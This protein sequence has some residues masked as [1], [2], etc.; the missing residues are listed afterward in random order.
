MSHSGSSSTTRS[1]RAPRRRSCVSRVS[2]QGLVPHDR[3]AR[4]R[5]R[6][7]GA[8]RLL[9]AGPLPVSYW[10]GAVGGG[11]R[12]RL[13]KLQN[14][15]A[16]AA[17]LAGYTAVI[18][19]SDQL[20]AVGG[21]NGDT[22]MLAVARVTEIGIGIVSTGIVLAGTDLGGARHRLAG[23]FAG[24]TTGSANRLGFATTRRCCRRRWTIRSPPWPAGA[25]W[26]ITWFA[27][28]SS[29]GQRLP[30][31]CE[32]HVGQ[33]GGNS[34]LQPRCHEAAARGGTGF[35]RW[36]GGGSDRRHDGLC[37]GRAFGVHA[38]D[39]RSGSLQGLG[40]AWDLPR[41][42]GVGRCG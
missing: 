14:F 23:L 10:S 31:S 26:Q 11:V 21:L 5:R 39:R 18:I 42:G 32:G 27:C 4:R 1:G 3:H 28:R 7:R 17:A 41:V 37:C 20:G 25:Q 8:D 29:I 30:S 16:Y 24:L 15:A 36:Y 35:W 22:F 34:G 6:D 12:V 9:F 19:A 33:A 40:R 2:A 13:D 38:F